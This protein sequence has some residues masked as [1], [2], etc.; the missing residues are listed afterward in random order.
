MKRIKLLILAA[1]LI[2]TVCVSG[3]SGS[4]TTTVSSSNSLQ[5]SVT[6]SSDVSE[7]SIVFTA[8]LAAEKLKEA[9]RSKY[10]DASFGEVEILEPVNEDACTLGIKGHTLVTDSYGHIVNKDFNYCAIIYKLS[11]GIRTG[12][13]VI[14]TDS[15]L[16]RDYESLP[17]EFAV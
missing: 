9:I 4:V 17:K 13:R 16:Y 2:G 10:P 12:I 7:E 1:L 3:C 8:E 11:T 15:I 5:S 6:E 14:S